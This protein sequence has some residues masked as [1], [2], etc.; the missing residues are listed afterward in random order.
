VLRAIVC[1]AILLAGSFWLPQTGGNFVIASPM[2]DEATDK[3]RAQIAE[4]IKAHWSEGAVARHVVFVCDLHPDGSVT[5]LRLVTSSG[6]A[7][8]DIAGLN[9]IKLAVPFPKPPTAFDGVKGM[10]VKFYTSVEVDI[11]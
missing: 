6:S 5:R 8:L 2:Y 9:A 7:K 1:V 10:Q 3:Y 11:F 4:C